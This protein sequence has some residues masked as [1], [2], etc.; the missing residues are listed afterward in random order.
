MGRGDLQAVTERSTESV[1][2]RGT[3]DPVGEGWQAFLEE[4]VQAGSLKAEQGIFQSRGARANPPQQ[5]HL[6]ELWGKYP[7]PTQQASSR[8]VPEAEEK[9]DPC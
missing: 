5:L 4:R 7:P 2:P 8:E 9:P 6:S 1:K 3:P